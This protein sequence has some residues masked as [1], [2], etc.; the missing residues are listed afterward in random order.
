MN[1][2]A[3]RSGSVDQLVRC[4]AAALRAAGMQH[5]LW[6]LGQSHVVGLVRT[7][8]S[9]P[10]VPQVLSNEHRQELQRFFAPDVGALAELLRED[11]RTIW[12]DYEDAM[13]R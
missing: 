13:T 5:L 1:R 2:G 10:S 11:L 8:N 6:K 4:T 3:P 12:F 7:L 9:R